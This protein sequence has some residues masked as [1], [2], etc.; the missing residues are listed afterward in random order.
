MKQESIELFKR[1]NKLSNKILELTAEQD[2]IRDERD[3]LV[4]ELI[5]SENG[6]R[7]FDVNDRIY[8]AVCKRG[9]YFLR[10]PKPSA[11]STQIEFDE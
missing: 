10:A 6:T 7:Q 4:R 2:R 8:S 3:T 5:V 9:R 1:I 11:E